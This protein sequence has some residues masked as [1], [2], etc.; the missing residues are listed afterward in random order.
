MK[1]FTFLMTGLLSFS[2]LAAEPTSYSFKWIKGEDMPKLIKEARKRQ[3]VRK[4]ASGGVDTSLMSEEYKSMVNQV[5]TIKTGDQLASMLD[6]LDK[7][8]DSYPDDAK[9]LGSLLLLLKPMRGVVYRMIP[10]VEK[11]KVTHSFLRNQVKTL[12]SNMRLYLPLDHW[13]A[14]FAYLTE[15]FAVNGKAVAQFENSKLF[16]KDKSTAIQQFQNFLEADVYNSFA[17]AVQRVESIQFKR[18][19]VW[20][21]RLVFGG[22]SF[23]G[24]D[25][26]NRY[27]YVQEGE[28]H[29]TLSSLHLGMHYLYYVTAYDIND[30]LKFSYRVGRLYG[31][32]GFDN[33]IVGVPNYKVSKELKKFPHLFEMRPNGETKM[34]ASFQHLREG[35]RQVRLAR[36]ELRDEAPNR[37]LVLNPEK[38]NPWDEDFEKQMA[39]A[40]CLVGKDSDEPGVCPVHSA[41]TG[42]VVKIN[43]FAFYDKAPRDLKSLMATDWDLSTEEITDSKLKVTYPNY[44]WGRPTSWNKD[45]YKAYFPEL[46]SGEE[47]AKNVRVLRQAYGGEFF[48]APFAF[49]VE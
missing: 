29:L 46:K 36:E 11:P 33:E 35:I 40:E 23:Q 2:T 41:I 19:V 12:A 17:Q 24:D 9:M 25:I 22:S 31:I 10:M 26:E 15:P 14:G 42:E 39:V 20:D 1:I 45:A 21:N 4:T 47:V 38:F 7:K 44:Y 8:V 32:D 43:L 49:F 16:A 18:P 28:R 27:R 6:T 30:S 13:E 48:G 5:L 37:M 3:Q 34:R